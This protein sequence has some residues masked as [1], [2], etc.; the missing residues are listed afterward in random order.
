LT[1]TS[2]YQLTPM[3]PGRRC[4]TVHSHTRW[5]GMGWDALVTQFVNASIEIRWVISAAHPIPSQCK[6]YAWLWRQMEGSNAQSAVASP[7][8]KSLE[9]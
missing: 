6:F 2:T 5:D 9:G 1:G 3:G 8:L 7:L 4:L